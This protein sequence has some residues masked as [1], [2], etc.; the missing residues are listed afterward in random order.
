MGNVLVS[1]PLYSYHVENSNSFRLGFVLLWDLCYIL[2]VF[3]DY[4]K[5][6][7]LTQVCAGH[8]SRELA[9]DMDSSLPRDLRNR[10]NVKRPDNIDY[11]SGYCILP[12][13]KMSIDLHTA[14]LRLVGLDQWLLP[15]ND[16]PTAVTV[17]SRV[18]HVIE[19]RLKALTPAN[20]HG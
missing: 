19:S 2:C 15:V 9:Y 6:T 17:S 14:V 3:V 11:M 1:I 7:Y 13:S 4:W 5:K 20:K 18:C 12:S 10:S 8:Q 16:M